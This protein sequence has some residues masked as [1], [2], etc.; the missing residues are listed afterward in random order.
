MKSVRRAFMLFLLAFTVSLANA[1]TALVSDK[2]TIIS[3]ATNDEVKLDAGGR[4]AHVLRYIPTGNRRSIYQRYSYSL[5]K[6]REDAFDELSSVRAS[7]RF[8][9]LDSTGGATLVFP[10]YISD[11]GS[12]QDYS[13]LAHVPQSGPA[14]FLDGIS[15]LD[16]FTRI[17]A[18][19]VSGQVR[20][21]TRGNTKDTVT[22][23]TDSFVAVTD[24]ANNIPTRYLLSTEYF[25]YDGADRWLYVAA[26]DAAHT[27]VSAVAGHI[28]WP[29]LTYVRQFSYG[30]G[31]ILNIGL[32]INYP[33]DICI[34][35][36]SAEGKSQPHDMY[37]AADG[38]LAKFSPTGALEWKI[39]TPGSVYTE[40]DHVD[41]VG[42]VA[43]RVT[44][45]T[46]E[47][48][49]VS[50]VGTITRAVS[51]PIALHSSFQ[52]KVDSAGQISLY[53]PIN[54]PRELMVINTVG[55]LKRYAVPGMS[56]GYLDQWNNAFFL[57]KTGA[58]TSLN[59]SYNLQP[60]R[61]SEIAVKRGNSAKVFLD[62]RTGAPRVDRQATITS[63]GGTNFTTPAVAE[64][65][66][67][68]TETYFRVTAPASGTTG[69]GWVYISYAGRSLK[70][71]VTVTP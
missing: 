63:T 68:A 37:V 10:R 39:E 46:V 70:L 48:L 69:S 45:Q 65:N 62:L 19:A 16:T 11:F 38:A 4:Y 30:L 23:P 27:G 1:Q 71:R 12:P 51:V 52:Y 26:S 3:T 21:S 25:P 28:T 44:G 40:V 34:L 49:F 58:E 42:L 18:T 57:S 29:G 14:K 56:L 17:E 32:P 9:A 2:R 36:T 8:G 66:P 41:I 6:Y 24:A 53:D 43:K 20:I 64:F 35:P 13:V 61:A 67:G 31:P 5:T 47:F 22:G 33:R 7:A 15:Y 59:V 54:F 60:L 55:V 50:P